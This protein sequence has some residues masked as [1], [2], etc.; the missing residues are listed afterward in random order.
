MNNVK[1]F[2]LAILF[3]TTFLTSCNDDDV[4]ATT[5][6]LDLNITGL[7][8]LGSDYVYEGWLIVDGSPVSA[9]IFSVNANGELSK[10]SFEIDQETLN[11]A[12]TYV[13]TIEPSPDND[14]APSDV[15]ILAGD[16]SGNNAAI[17]VN[18]GAAIGTDFLAATGSYILATPT[19][20]GAMTDENSG[21][22][23][24]DPAGG[25]GAGLDLPTLPAG[26]VY[27]GW[28]VI[29]GS[30]IS[31]GTF[32]SVTGM[33]NFSGFSATDAGSPPFPGEDFLINPPNGLN[34]PVDLAGKTVVISVEPSP[35][36]STAPFLLKPLVGAVPADAVD[37]T[38]YGMNNNAAATN[39]TGTVT[40]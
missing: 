39:P 26:W 4:T 11:N 5:G 8:D 22:W 15:H 21:I 31:T 2:F 20:G 36:N 34:F 16:F 40:R 7:Q 18:H 13:L 28:A 14:P 32:T 19:D 38:L 29:D 30:P 17:T 37:H 24:L 25:P 9:G 12:A 33:D 27:E 1:L 23:W 6:N 3:G 35:D 10:S